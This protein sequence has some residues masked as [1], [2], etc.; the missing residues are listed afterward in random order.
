MTMVGGDMFDHAL[1]A[2][3]DALRR[4]LANP[5]TTTTVFRELTA[6][7]RGGAWWPPDLG[8]PSATGGQ[9]ASRYAIFPTARRLVVQTGNATRV[10]DTGE[11]RIGGVQQ[12]QADNS[13]SW[14][15]TSQ[16]G[17]FDVTDLREL[18]PSP[19]DMA[20]N[21]PVPRHRAETYPLQPEA[22]PAPE[23]RAQV[24]TAGDAAVIVAAIES[25]AGLHKRGI[26][27]D[28]EFAAKKADLLNRL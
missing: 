17:T 21:E 18:N 26:L 15:F 8:V 6:G 25:L 20:A 11:H 23:S 27:S 4:D 24:A 5:L 28:E 14:S 16:L 19:A 22:A 7:S 1:K 13:G 3:V 2:R 10:F 12:Q 9:N